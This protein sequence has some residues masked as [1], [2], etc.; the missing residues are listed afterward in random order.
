MESVLF[1]TSFVLEGF[2]LVLLGVKKYGTFFN[3]I[4]M[5]S[6]MWCL[7]GFISNLGLYDSYAPSSLVNLLIISGSLAFFFADFLHKPISRGF[8]VG[9]NFMR[10]ESGVGSDAR[11]TIIIV[12]NIISIIIILPLLVKAASIIATQGWTG[13]RAANYDESSQYMSTL[14]TYLHTY[15]VRPCTIATLLVGVWSIL[16]VDGS[17]KIPFIF[18]IV[19][20]LLDVAVTAGRNTLF[21][22]LILILFA[23]L[24]L[25]N[26]SKGM[27]LRKIIRPRYVVPVGL[28]GLLLFFV[29][30]ERSGEDALGKTIFQYFFAGPVYLSQLLSNA[31]LPWIPNQDYMFGAATFGFIINVPL[32]IGLILGFSVRP[33]SYW[34]GSVLTSKVYSIAPEIAQNATCTAF[35]AFL[36]DWGY[37]GIVIGPVI[38][39]FATL[40]IIKKY[41]LYKNL[42]WSS[43]LLYCIYLLYRTSFRWDP[44]DISVLMIG[45]LVALFSFRKKGVG[46]GSVSP[47]GLGD[48]SYSQF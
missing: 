33:S 14:Q 34:I 9:C 3:P 7:I 32:F 39:A 43:I 5:F 28:I 38:L 48:N 6:G 23:F 10:K 25:N 46:Y 12:C 45:L 13:L 24:M 11:C 29:T 8:S 20:A 37:L 19:N 22:A 41:M 2:V 36:L 21:S 18:G 44:V 31:S 35:Y 40:Y 27:I 1:S 42:F 4:F 16:G 47:V 15:F 30:F 26:N 17:S